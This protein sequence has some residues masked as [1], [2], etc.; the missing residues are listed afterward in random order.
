[1]PRVDPAEAD[2]LTAP[3]ADDDAGELAET[4]RRT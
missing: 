2:E 3:A 1:V 4:L